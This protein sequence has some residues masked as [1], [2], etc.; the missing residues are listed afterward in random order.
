VSR[1]DRPP[2]MR[3]APMSSES[4]VM[5]LGAKLNSPPAG[6]GLALI[7]QAIRASRLGRHGALSTGA[8]VRNAAGFRDF[9]RGEGPAK[10][11]QN[12]GSEATS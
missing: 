5:E 10:R 1:V 6:S 3:I 12:S 4:A 8:V 2:Y 11:T 9:Y 7:V